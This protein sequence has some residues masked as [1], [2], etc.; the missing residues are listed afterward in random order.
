MNDED[1]FNALL[2]GDF[3]N[4]GLGEE[5]LFS[6]LIKKNIIRVIT[7]EYDYLAFEALT[8]FECEYTLSK[9]STAC[10]Q[11]HEYAWTFAK[12]FN[13]VIIKNYDN[14]YDLLDLEDDEYYRY[15][16][17]DFSD[18]IASRHLT[19]AQKKKYKS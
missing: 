9:Y 4:T 5:E 17:E 10:K 14:F 12:P 3:T 18:H 13:P 11:G 19:S 7:A 16:T 1:L 6:L 8:D 2:S 15:P